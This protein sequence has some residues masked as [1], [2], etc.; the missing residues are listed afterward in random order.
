LN[1]LTTIPKVKFGSI[2]FYSFSDFVRGLF[3]LRKEGGI[4]LESLG[5]VFGLDYDEEKRKMQQEVD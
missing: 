5:R 3:E 1:N 2:D 4:S